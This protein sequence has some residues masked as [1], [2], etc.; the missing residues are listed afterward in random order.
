M[1]LQSV[2][3]TA[4]LQGGTLNGGMRAEANNSVLTPQATLDGAITMNGGV[5]AYG[6]AAVNVTGG[7]Y[8]RFAGADASYFVMGTNNIN[9]CGTDLGLSARTAGQVFETYHYT[10]NFY[11]FSGGTFSDG[12]SV[13]GLRLFDAVSVAGNVLGGG[14]TLKPSPVP[15]PAAWLL[16]LLA[17]PAVAARVRRHRTA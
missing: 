3:T 16:M 15:E 5:F 1:R 14:C 6:N 12:Q 17:L 8:T 13:V 10:G 4:T 2:T 9:F 7:S 11:T